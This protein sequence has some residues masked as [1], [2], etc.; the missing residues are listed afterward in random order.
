VVQAVCVSL[1]V[2]SETAFVGKKKK[3]IFIEMHGTTTTNTTYSFSI[4][5][6]L[7]VLCERS[8][9]AYVFCVIYL[10]APP[11]SQNVYKQVLG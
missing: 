5:E 11:F 4:M 9:M 8:F 2:W 7:R 1:A 10:K 6:L 3:L